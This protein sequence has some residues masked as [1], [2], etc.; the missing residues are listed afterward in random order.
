[1]ATEL[2]EI[3]VGT[4]ESLLVQ[5]YDKDNDDGST[6]IDLT[7]CTTFAATGKDSAGNKKNFT[8]ATVDG[9]TTLGTLKLTY[10][11]NTFPAATYDIQITYTAPDGTTRGYPSQGNQLKL[12]VN[13]AN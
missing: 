7:G 1:M 5:L 12:K 9:A 4:N 2:H 8:A 11:T 6:G 10:A 3:I 13:G